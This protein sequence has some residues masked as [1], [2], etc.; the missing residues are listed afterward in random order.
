MTEHPIINQ[1]KA[2]DQAIMAEDFD[3]LL[4]IYTDD[5]VLVVQPGMNAVG[6]AQIRQHIDF[7][8]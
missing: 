3:T 8:L 2:A 4:D 6:K 1:I 7:I 5:A